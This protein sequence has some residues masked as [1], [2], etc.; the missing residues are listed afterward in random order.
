MNGHGNGSVAYVFCRNVLLSHVPNSLSER[1]LWQKSKEQSSNDPCCAEHKNGLS[2]KTTNTTANQ[3]NGVRAHPRPA[4]VSREGRTA[5]AERA[6]S[7]AP[8]PNPPGQANSLRLTA[9][10]TSIYSSGKTTHRVVSGDPCN[11]TLKKN[12]VVKKGQS[13]QAK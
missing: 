1:A 4:T 2:D 11:I 3:G 12:A 5:E 7:R 9:L 10:Q 8:R 13:T 6:R